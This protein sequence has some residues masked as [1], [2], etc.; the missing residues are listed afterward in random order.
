MSV[1]GDEFGSSS[2]DGFHVNAQLSTCSRLQACGKLELCD[3]VGLSRNR[4]LVS[5]ITSQRVQW[6]IQP[7]GDV[8]FMNLGYV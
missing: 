8:L 3:A 1:A 5:S 2:E 7:R 4:N 6:Q